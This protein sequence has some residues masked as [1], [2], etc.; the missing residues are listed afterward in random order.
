MQNVLLIDRDGTLVEEPEDFQVDSL[1][2]IKLCE[3]VI[4]SLLAL[5]NAGYRFVMVTNQDGLGTSS[6]PQ[7]SF[8][9]THDFII[10]LF[11]SQGIYFSDI[12]ICPHRENDNCECRK[13]KIGLLRDFL[14]KTSIDRNNSWVIGDRETDRQ[15]ANNIG[16]GFQPVAK[17]HGWK[18]IVREILYRQRSATVVRKTKET[19]IAVTI[20]LDNASL[21][22]IN[23]PIA[24][25]S[26][27]L[28]QIAKHGGFSL[29]I[30]ATGD[31]EVDEH[32]LVEDCALAL[33]EA[34]KKALGNKWGIARYGFTLPMDESLATVTLDLCG[35]SH[36]IFEGQFTRE[37]VGGLATEMIPHFFNSFA[38][39]L[40]ATLHMTIKGE[41]HHHMVEACF[42]ALGRTLRQACMQCDNDLPSTKG[43]L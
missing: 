40:G 34:F 38:S 12:F 20:T 6:F 23:T 11:A 1:S 33:G 30:N 5:N 32:H 24:F 17:N 9:T 35:R 7:E 22:S 15:L 14:E 10:N 26:H 3:H 39:S 41:N 25:F 43:V 36:C 27:M 2:K 19:A 42:K 37:F 4:P 21:T 8:Q 28:E 13:P 31:T 16:V 29:E 18:D